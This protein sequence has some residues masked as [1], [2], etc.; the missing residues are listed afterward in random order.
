MVKPDFASKS[1]FKQAELSHSGADGKQA[2]PSQSG[3]KIL[4]AGKPQHPIEGRL[5]K[6]EKRLILKETEL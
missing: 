2:E 4:T 3:V 5:N 1:L 6:A